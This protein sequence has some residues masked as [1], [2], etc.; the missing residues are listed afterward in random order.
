MRAIMAMPI[1]KRRHRCPSFAC[2]AS[3]VTAVIFIVWQCSFQPIRSARAASSRWDYRGRGLSDWDT[4]KSRYQLPVEA[5]DVLSACEN[6]GIA[7]AIFIG[8]SRGGLTLHFLAA[9]RPALLAGIVLNDIGPVIEIAGLLQIRHY[10]AA[11]AA[12]AIL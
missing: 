1:R 4:D 12:A 11:A 7:K 10:S 2:R 6:L 8:T 5:Q 9:M 3:A